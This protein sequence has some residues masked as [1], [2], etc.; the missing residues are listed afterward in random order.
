M[1]AAHQSTYRNNPGRSP[2]KYIDR[3]TGIEDY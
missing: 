1:N 2:D 3:D